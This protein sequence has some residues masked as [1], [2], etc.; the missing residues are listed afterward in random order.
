MDKRRS[1]SRFYWLL[2]LV[3][4]VA[5]LVVLSGCGRKPP[6]DFWSM[7][8]DDSTQVAALIAEWK[9]ELLSDFADDTTLSDM[10]F[11]IPD[12]TR[13]SLRRD[14]KDNKFRQRWF[15][16]TFSRIFR[17]DSIV[18][19]LMPTIDTTITVKLTEYFLGDVTIYTDSI[20]HFRTD[21]VIGGM[22]FKVYDSTFSRFDSVVHETLT[23][24]CERALYL[25]RDS[26][27]KWHV[28][29]I[30]P[31]VYYA[32]DMATAPYLGCLRVWNST[33]RADTIV[34]RPDTLHFGMQRLYSLDSLFEYVV[35]ESLTVEMARTSLL[36]H[37]WWNPEDILPFVH[38][39]N[40]RLT[41]GKVTDKTKVNFRFAPEDTGLKQIYFEIV[42]R[43]NITEYSP[44][45]NSTIWAVPVRVKSAR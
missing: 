32:P 20:T 28:K 27:K 7:D 12:T 18:D 45:F 39:G 8:K 35:G 36:G 42:P 2:P 33:G 6:A 14:M 44:S 1:G 41:V 3:G 40:R 24:T 25:E 4:V 17:V 22:P 43:I 30:K 34:L 26:V 11:F 9:Q 5:V 21:T 10:I 23:A 29:R 15:P 13:L 37:L 16:R 31:G 19:S 38:I